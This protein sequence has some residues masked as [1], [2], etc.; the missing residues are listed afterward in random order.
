[1]AI[2]TRRRKKRKRKDNK[3]KG[4]A[5]KTTVIID[6]EKVNPNEDYQT[7]QNETAGEPVEFGN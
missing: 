4:S 1:M 5:K 3:S 2:I 6:G 7:G